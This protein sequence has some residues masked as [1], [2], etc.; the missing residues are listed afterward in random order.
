MPM[1]TTYKGP[2]DLPDVI[3]VFPLPG[4]LLFLSAS[5]AGPLPSM[6]IETGLVSTPDFN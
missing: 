3:P 1:N 2:E 5:T 6:S 4:A